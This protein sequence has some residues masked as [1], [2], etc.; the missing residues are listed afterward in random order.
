MSRDGQ[1]L[2]RKPRYISDY[3]CATPGTA[4]LYTGR[5]RRVAILWT[6]TQGGNTMAWFVIALT[7]D[8]GGAT[9]RGS[10]LRLPPYE[11]EQDA[12]A[13]ISWQVT[14]GFDRDDYCI[15]TPDPALP[16]VMVA[17][18]GRA[19]LIRNAFWTDEAFARF[20]INCW[21]HLAS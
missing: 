1:H 15:A 2:T 18:D 4:G 5:V 14:G 17:K 21:G 7:G 12:Q 13:A 11:S 3:W 16:G 6:D 19:V 8:T 10:P 20:M 9:L